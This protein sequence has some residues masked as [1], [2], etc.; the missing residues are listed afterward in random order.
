MSH[1]DHAGAKK[2]AG[3]CGCA[4]AHQHPVDVL[5]AEH[6]TILAVLGAMA[7]E[8]RHLLAGGSVRTAFWNPALE[9][10]EQ[11]ADRCHHGKE[12]L[13]LFVELERAGL[14]PTHGPTVCMRNEHELGRQGRRAMLDALHA[15]DGS[16]LAVAVGAYVEL[17]RD[18]IEKE[19]QVLFPMAK[20]ML[21]E[22]AVAR[23][24]TAFARVEH[25]D[26]GEGAHARYEELARHLA[27]EGAAT[28]R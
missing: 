7:N 25:H 12:E 2:A 23:L 17:L 9:F 4:C 3:S 8:Q 5:S 1:H 13:A 15:R 14:P 16:G 6:Q 22:A 27:A 28:T 19:D 20:S 24:R 10:L 11:Y 21:D 26:M 18:H